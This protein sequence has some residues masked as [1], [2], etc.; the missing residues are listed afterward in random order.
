MERDDV[1]VRAPGS[2][3]LWWLKAVVFAFSVTA[4]LSTMLGLTGY[5]A[6]EWPFVGGVVGIALFLSA[7][8]VSAIL[9][10][11]AKSIDAYSRTAIKESGFKVYFEGAE[12]KPRKGRTL[13]IA[14]VLVTLYVA[15]VLGVALLV[16]LAIV[17][18]LGLPPLATGIHVGAKVL[19]LVGVGGLGILMG[20]S[21]GVYFLIRRMAKWVPAVAWAV[22]LVLNV[23]DGVEELAQVSSLGRSSMRA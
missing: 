12:V 17:E 13:M 18:G 11:V 19:A 4:V 7:L 10:V 1:C 8:A 6:G 15:A 9:L 20:L 3:R 16:S 21:F 14:V 22:H 2:I 23:G 5:P